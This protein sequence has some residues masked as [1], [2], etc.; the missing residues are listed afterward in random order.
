MMTLK[1]FIKQLS[2]IVI[3]TNDVICHNFNVQ[4]EHS[5]RLTAC[6]DRSLKLIQPP[7]SWL[8]VGKSATNGLDDAV[9][10]NDVHHKTSTRPGNTYG[11]PD[12]AYLDNVLGELAQ[13]GVVDE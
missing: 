9:T 5:N 7:S 11:Y 13:N 8:Q 6:T 4:N 10:W 2:F 12:P 1:L 3:Q